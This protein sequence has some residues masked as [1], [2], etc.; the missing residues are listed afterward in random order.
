[1]TVIKDADFRKEI[2]SSPKCC[3]LFYGEEDY[4][5]SFALTV[6]A[7][8]ISPDPS[9]SFFNE[10]KFDALSYSPE[11]LL[12]AM[13]PL[14][15]MAERKLII[16]SGL[17]FNAMKPYELEALCN[18]LSQLEDYDYNTVIIS[19]ASDRIDPGRNPKKPSATLKALGEHATLVNFEK[20]TPAKLAAWIGKHFEH[21]G[22]S[23]SPDVCAF[24]IELCGRD[25]FILAGETDKLSFY[26]KQH[27]RDTVTREDVMN[28]ATPAVEYDVFAFS[29][30]IASRKKAE[31]LS[32]LR[33]FRMKKTDPILIMGELTNTLC[34]MASI[35]ALGADGL[36]AAEISKIINLHE[37]AVSLM[38]RNRIRPEI[39]EKLLVR[40]READLELK[41]STDGYTV[42][43]KL[44]CT[45]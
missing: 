18:T 38:L 4:M 11:A 44:I 35:A 6:A 30:A 12:D 13:M 24:V 15:M 17:D 37:Y 10:I 41:S 16:V 28:V 9:L 22:V 42:L 26:A 39:C 45:I 43:E 40:C 33:D 25:M 8:A 29:N 27:G 36:T 3:Y 5:K 14:P 34:N 20:N 19:V 23:A 21:N 32:I 7:E 31:A 1:M 2:K